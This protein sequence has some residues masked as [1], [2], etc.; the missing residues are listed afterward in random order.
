MYPLPDALVRMMT[1]MHSEAGRAWLAALPALL[2]DCAR[3]WSLTLGPPYPAAFN[4]VAPARRADG[5]LAVLKVGLP[6]R[7]ALSGLNAL[8]LYDGQGMVRLLDADGERGAQLL[9]QLVPGTPLAT[10]PDDAVATTIAANL[11][12]QLRRPAPTGHHY[13]T[14]AD[15]GRG[16]ERLRRSYDGGTGPLP[17]ALVERAEHLFADLSDSM[18]AP[19]VLHG[20]LHHDNIVA[21]TRAPWLAIDPKGVVGEPAYETGALLRNP[22][23]HLLTM[24][25][26]ARLSCRRVDQLADELGFDRARIRGWGLAQAVLSAWWSI[27]DAGTG[28]EFG[29]AVAELLTR[30]PA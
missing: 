7:E 9:E 4:Y 25:D 27:E 3:R 21:A 30:A 17:G 15:W 28:W 13:P 5:M 18:A 22:M 23:P 29:I 16:F 1:S 8:R 20:D 6:D 14:V 2:D 10:M 24:P 11:M 12:R 19:V 26:P